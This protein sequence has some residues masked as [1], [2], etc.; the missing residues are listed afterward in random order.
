MESNFLKYIYDQAT[1]STSGISIVGPKG[2]GKT[3]SLYYMLHKL[4]K[5]HKNSVVIFANGLHISS[6]KKW[7]DYAKKVLPEGK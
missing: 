2:V 3:T 6:S 1:T 7:K 4:R 5:E